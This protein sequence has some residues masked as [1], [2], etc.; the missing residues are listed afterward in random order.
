MLTK[1]SDKILTLIG[2]AFTFGLA[3]WMVLEARAKFMSC[4]VVVCNS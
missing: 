2:L 1:L 3:L 4:G